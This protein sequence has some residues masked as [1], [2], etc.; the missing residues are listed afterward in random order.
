MHPNQIR[1][2]WT[3]IIQKCLPQ[4]GIDSKW[5]H[6]IIK[7]NKCGINTTEMQNKMRGVDELSPSSRM[8]VTSLRVIMRASI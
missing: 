1:L 7:A 5:C 8:D 3:L 2:I 6:N 4:V